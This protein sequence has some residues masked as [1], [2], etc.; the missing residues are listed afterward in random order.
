MLYVDARKKLKEKTRES[1]FNKDEEGDR[2]LDEK[3]A[4]ENEAEVF[5][6]VALEAR[7]SS[8]INFDCQLISGILSDTRPAKKLTTENKSDTLASSSQQL[9]GII[10]NNFYLNI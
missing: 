6:E 7:T 2:W 10:D 5:P 3:V 1:V 4:D 8:L 9:E